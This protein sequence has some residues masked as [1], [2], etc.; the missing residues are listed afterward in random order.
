MLL[1][2][3]EQDV[4]AAARAGLGPGPA[5]HLVLLQLVEGQLQ[6]T[7]LA[8]HGP[9]GARGGLG[10]HTGL[11]FPTWNTEFPQL[12]SSVVSSATSKGITWNKLQQRRVG[13]TNL[14]AE[15]P[16]TLRT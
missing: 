10:K 11:L 15:A 14:A 9:Q 3:P 4:A 1:E 16:Q 2:L 6:V 5:E 13:G 8:Q 7:E 12:W